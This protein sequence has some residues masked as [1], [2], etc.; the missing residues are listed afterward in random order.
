MA[1][2]KNKVNK[3]VNAPDIKV[4]QKENFDLENS[5]TFMSSVLNLQRTTTLNR[6]TKYEK[7]RILGTRAAQ[8]QNGMSPVFLEKGKHVGLPD[9]FKDVV[10]SSIDLAKLELQLKSSPLIIRRKLPSGKIK[11][12]TTQELN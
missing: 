2:E 7:A 11:E 10:K 5:N 12:K 6:L 3:A 4:E 1:E 8:I 9:E